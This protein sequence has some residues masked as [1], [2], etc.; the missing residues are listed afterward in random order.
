MDPPD[1]S[2]HIELDEP[3]DGADGA[4]R[5]RCGSRW[6]AW[7]LKQRSK[8]DG[9]PQRIRQLRPNR[10]VSYAGG[11]RADYGIAQAVSAHGQRLSADED[12]QHSGGAWRVEENFIKSRPREPRTYGVEFGPRQIT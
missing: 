4:G 8:T 9:G 1:G 5:A 10:R 7:R 12:P 6:S 2:E 11:G 3:E